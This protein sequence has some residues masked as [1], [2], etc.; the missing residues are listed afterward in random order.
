LCTQPDAGYLKL[1]RG[2]QTGKSNLSRQPCDTAMDKIPQRLVLG[3]PVLQ[4]QRC[5]RAKEG[6]HE[7]TERNPETE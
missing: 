4:E 5:D 1:D 7:R 3:Q 6:S 2:E